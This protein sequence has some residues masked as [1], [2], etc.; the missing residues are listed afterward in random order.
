VNCKKILL[1]V[2]A[3]FFIFVSF[4]QGSKTSLFVLGGPNLSSYYGNDFIRKSRSFYPGFQAGLG[5]KSRVKQH[6]HIVA[7]LRYER[8]GSI[9]KDVTL[10]GNYG[11]TFGRG[12]IYEVLDFL[13]VPLYMEY[14][15]G[16]KIKFNI[17]GGL[18]AGFLQKQVSK[19]RLVDLFSGQPVE[20]NTS[21]NLST[22][23]NAGVLFGFNTL[24]PVTSKIQLQVVIRDE[25]GLV[26]IKDPTIDSKIKTNSLNLLIGMN[27]QL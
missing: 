16:S 19:V 6:L 18:F 13:S 7:A 12:N 21:P 1:T 22:E 5:I 10:A 17:E 23:H 25:L 9:I 4:A 26:D 11:N 14:G 3:C 15:F 27:F 8:L 20:Y 24:L 2:F